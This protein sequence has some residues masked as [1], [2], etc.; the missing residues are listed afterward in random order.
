MKHLSGGGSS[1]PET[2]ALTD[3][4][5][6]PAE[7]LDRFRTVAETHVELEGYAPKPDQMVLVLNISC[8]ELSE[9]ASD[10]INAL[11]ESGQHFRVSFR[12]LFKLFSFCLIFS[13]LDGAYSNCLYNYTIL[14]F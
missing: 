2:T 10:V 9:S 11:A 4:R 6:F 12:K 1:A 14:C 3:W 13:I 7:Y 5:V 8:G